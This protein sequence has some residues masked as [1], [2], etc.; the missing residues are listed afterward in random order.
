M[1]RRVN[2]FLGLRSRS[3]WRA[4]PNWTAEKS[5]RTALVGLS[6]SPTSKVLGKAVHRKVS[7]WD[8]ARHWRKLFMERYIPEAFQH[9]L[10]QNHLEK[11]GFLE[12]LLILVAGY[13][14]WPTLQTLDTSEA[15]YYSGSWHLGTYLLGQRILCRESLEH[16]KQI[17][18]KFSLQ[19][20]LLKKDSIVP[21][22]KAK[23]FKGP[24]PFAQNRQK[25]W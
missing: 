21:A 6:G 17:S 7:H 10:L 23:I 1:A 13:L 16:R 14:W 18:L 3:S 24:H 20:P 15:V 9:T 4:Q 11:C 22:N 5:L 2:L 8:T 19:H 25:G 12:L